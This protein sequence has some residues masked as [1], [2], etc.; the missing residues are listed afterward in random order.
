MEFHPPSPFK[1]LACAPMHQLSLVE[2]YPVWLGVATL[3]MA[4]RSIAC[5]I[6]LAVLLVV[7]PFMS[8][9]T[10]AHIYLS[11]GQDATLD[12]VRKH[13]KFFVY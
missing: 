4:G 13:V 2:Q 1:L 11:K 9:F 8:L 12:A 6:D 10:Q 5:L 3:A 7:F